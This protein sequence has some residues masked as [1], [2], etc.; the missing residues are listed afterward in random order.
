MGYALK[1]GQFRKKAPQLIA[2]GIAIAIIV[3]LVFDFFEDVV[4]GGAPVASEPV[5]SL[6]LS[7]TSGVTSTVRIWGYSGIFGLM[8]L[9]SSSLPIPSEVIL[10]FAPVF[11]QMLLNQFAGIIHQARQIGRDAPLRL[12]QQGQLHRKTVVRPD[13]P[14]I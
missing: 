1:F 5:I 9:E 11:G 14:F 2:V 10:P 13:A 6:V 7:I 12:G 4:I 3:Y 8:L